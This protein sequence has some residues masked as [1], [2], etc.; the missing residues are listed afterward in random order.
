M[1]LKPQYIIAIACAVI[2]IALFSWSGSTPRA[3]PLRLTNPTRG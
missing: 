1:I 3:L 2:F